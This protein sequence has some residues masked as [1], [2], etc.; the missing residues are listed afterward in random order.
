MAVPHLIDRLD[1][2]WS[3]DGEGSQR[4]FYGIVVS[5]LSFI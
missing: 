1:G 3:L 4:F 2:N 5:F